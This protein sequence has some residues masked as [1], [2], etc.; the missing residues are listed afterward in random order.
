[1][2]NTVAFLP[3]VHIKQ[4]GKLTRAYRVAK[5]FIRDVQPGIVILGGDFM[6]IEALSWWLKDKRKTMEGKYYSKEVAKANRE[7]DSIQKLC[8][9]A[10]IVYLEG[11]HEYWVSQYLD[12]NPAMVGSIEIPTV[13]GLESRGVEWVKENTLYRVGKLNFLHGIYCNMYHA[14]KHLEELGDNCMYG[15]V[16]K[17]QVFVKEQRARGKT[18]G[19]WS[20]GCLCDLNPHWLRGHPNS[21]KHGFGYVEFR[22]DGEFQATLV[23]IQDGVMTF[24]GQTWRVK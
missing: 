10:K 5:L 4:D 23:N 9:E 18:Y 24:G 1:M 3:D 2:N 17:P 22:G 14:R 13:L 8:P 20:T 6:E 16:H 7:L 12:R 15:H 19:A 11:N 21:W